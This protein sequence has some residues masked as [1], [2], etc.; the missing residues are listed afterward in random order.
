MDAYQSLMALREFSDRVGPYY[1][2]ETRAM[3]L[4]CLVKMHKPKRL[5]ELGTGFGVSALWMARALW[6]N[7][8]GLIHVADRGIV[9]DAQKRSLFH[10]EELKPTFSE[11]FNSLVERHGLS[12]QV[13][14][15]ETSFPPYPAPEKE[16]DF[17]FSDFKHGPADLLEIL[18]F[19]L[20]K[21][22]SVSNFFIDSAPSLFGSYMMLQQLMTLFERGQVP[23]LLLQR[24][25]RNEVETLREF[26]RTHSIQAVPI[27][28]NVV[29]SQN[30]FMWLRIQPIDVMPRPL[31]HYRLDSKYYMSSKRINREER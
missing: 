7:G 19:Y 4:Y 25:A 21:M 30:S 11:Y 17:V 13:N 8:E 18:G 31:H 14:F 24:T 29:R 20:P 23:E 16:F 9:F 6:E 5:L 1:G 15:I 2:T 27:M 3:F 26:V 12:Q 22:A 28:E 10:P